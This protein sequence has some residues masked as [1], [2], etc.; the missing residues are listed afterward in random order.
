MKIKKI[1][2]GLVILFEDDEPINRKDIILTF[3]KYEL[4]FIFECEED[5]F[6]YLID[7]SSKDIYAL[8]GYSYNH[9]MKIFTGTNAI[10]LKENPEE[11]QDYNFYKEF[12]SEENKEMEKTND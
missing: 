8:S 2:E 12:V 6:D 11:Y 4:E 10:I 7:T 5:G 3:K 1:E 9:L